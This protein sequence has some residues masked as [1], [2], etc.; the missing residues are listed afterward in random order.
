MKCM[1]FSALTMV[2]TKLEALHNGVESFLN[3]NF[4][5]FLIVTLVYE[6]TEDRTR[7]LIQTGPMICFGETKLYEN[8]NASAEMIVLHW[9]CAI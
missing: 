8:K 3:G 4:S 5:I 7:Y 1:Q 9:D 6:R 2:E